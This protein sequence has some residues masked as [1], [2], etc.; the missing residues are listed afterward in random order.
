MLLSTGEVVAIDGI[1]SEGTA[2]ID[3]RALTGESQPAEKG[4]SDEVFAST[5]VITGICEGKKN[6]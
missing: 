2:T 5:V 4:V 6:R 1:I 3:Q